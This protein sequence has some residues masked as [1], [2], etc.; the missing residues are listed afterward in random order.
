MRI[1]FL[2]E[3]HASDSTLTHTDGD[4]CSAGAGPGLLDRIW[5]NID[6]HGVDDL[7]IACEMA[8]PIK[9]RP[10]R[11]S[12]LTGI[13]PPSPIIGIS[14]K[15][16]HSHV[17]IRVGV[18]E[19]LSESY[20]KVRSRDGWPRAE[21]LIAEDLRPRR[22]FGLSPAPEFAAWLKVRDLPAGTAALEENSPACQRM[23]QHLGPVLEQAGRFAR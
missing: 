15:H 3:L 11:E 23:L 1:A 7:E 19:V 12:G 10:D 18:E 17:G 13:H 9:V 20:R 16:A 5:A 8:D 14:I 4:V 21:G 22:R 6:R 2:L